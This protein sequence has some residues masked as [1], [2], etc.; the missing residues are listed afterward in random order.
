MRKGSPESGRAELEDA[1]GFGGSAG[2][3]PSPE[4]REVFV[5]REHAGMAF[6]DISAIVGVAENTVKSRMRY[7][8]EHLRQS[9]KKAG[10]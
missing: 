6:K 7:A 4:Q 2:R 3:S 1:D 10:I 8:L 5:M 9:L